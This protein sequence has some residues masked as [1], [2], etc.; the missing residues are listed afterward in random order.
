M[1][2]FEIE[3]E[4][5]C[6]KI[7]PIQNNGYN[8]RQNYNKNFMAKGIADSQEE[9][10]KIIKNSKTMQKV[11]QFIDKCVEGIN[12]SIDFVEKYWY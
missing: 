5:V 10:S 11:S 6:M 7:L 4:F 2:E 1:I 8:C 3:G 9:F 12:E